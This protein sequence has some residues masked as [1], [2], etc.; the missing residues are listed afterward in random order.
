MKVE[1]VLSAIS[2]QTGLSM[3]YS[4]QIVNLNRRI[5]IHVT[6]VELNQALDKLVSGTNLNYEVKNGKIY[7]F[8]KKS[9]E[10]ST[11]Q[12]KRKITGTVTDQ[13]GE[14]IIGANVVEKGTSNGT[15]SDADGNFTLEISGKE[16][17][18]ISYIG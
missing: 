17:L 6:D 14:V 1:T 16:P 2:Q 7:L 5:S 10:T 12:Q 3:A 13:S 11:T 8:E 15:I 9:T 4:K 18:V